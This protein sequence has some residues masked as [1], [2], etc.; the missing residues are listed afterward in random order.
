M[1]SF[2]PF[3]AARAHGKAYSEAAIG[4]K[5]HQT[6]M[7]VFVAF[8]NGL[9]TENTGLTGLAGVEVEWLNEF[10][11]QLISSSDVGQFLE[12]WNIRETHPQG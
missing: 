1:A 7:S 9:A 11:E 5:G 8:V 6:F 12:V 2:Q 3:A 10:R 4:Q